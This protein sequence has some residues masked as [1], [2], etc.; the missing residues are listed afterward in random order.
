MSAPAPATFLLLASFTLAGV[1]G[2]AAM[3]ACTSG[4]TPVCDDAGS[5]LIMQS[6]SDA[7]PAQPETGS[8]EAGG[9]GGGGE[10]GGD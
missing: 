4:T 7:S 5:C 2:S 8:S 9:D 3:A 6:G 1:A 10:A